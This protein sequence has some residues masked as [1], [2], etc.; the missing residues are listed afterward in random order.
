MKISCSKCGASYN[1]PAEKIPKGKANAR[2]VKCGAD[3]PINP[4][5]KY[6]GNTHQAILFEFPELTVPSFSKCN[7]TEILSPNKKG[8]YK[9]A[10][11]KFKVKILKAVG[12]LLNKVLTQ[13]EQVLRVAQGIAYFPA[14]IFFGNGYFTMMSNNYAILATNRRL[15]FINVNYRVTKP[16]HYIFQIPYENIKKASFGSIFS[17]IVF[18]SV[19][20]KSRTFTY[21]K[22]YLVKELKEFINN[23]L[24]PITSAAKANAQAENICPACFLPVEQGFKACPYCEAQYKTPFAAFARSLTMPGWGDIYLG[25]KGLGTLELLGALVVWGLVISFVMKDLTAGQSIMQSENIMLAAFIIVFYNF[26]DGILTYF[27]GKKGYLL[28]K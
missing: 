22:R 4:S 26:F 2:C 20:G 11:N 9:T 27:M 1:L 17:R 28:K 10:R 12:I 24:T 5:M 3:I 8:S 16:T 15:V 14:E 7:L 18:K 25:H 23:K 6:D 13:D 21:M 19:K